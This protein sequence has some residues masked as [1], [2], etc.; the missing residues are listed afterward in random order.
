MVVFL[1]VPFEAVG[2]FIFVKDSSRDQ[3]NFLIV[4]LVDGLLHRRFACWLCELTHCLAFVVDWR[5][6]KL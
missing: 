3:V 1:S 5:I 2:L 6:T 4:I